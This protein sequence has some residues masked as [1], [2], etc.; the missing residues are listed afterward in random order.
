MSLADRLAR[1]VFVLNGAAAGDDAAGFLAAL[2]GG[3]IVGERHIP[4]RGAAERFAP[5]ARDILREADWPSGPDAIVAVVGPGS[6]TGLRA[7]LSL[8]AG[9]AAGYGC[10]TVGVSLGAAFRAMPDAADAVCINVA[11]RNRCFVDWGDGR[12]EAYAPS[13]IVLPPGRRLLAGDAVDWLSEDQRAGR[14]VLPY[15]HPA[16]TA[17]LAA[18]MSDPRP[19]AQP[20]YVDAPEAKPPQGGLRP[21]PVG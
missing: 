18:A 17:I 20:L 19:V 16:P 7:S 3:R 14:V 21:A 6:F 10:P 1:R 2:D 9:L 8:A 13:E 15:R 5:L 12:V 4:G 11:R